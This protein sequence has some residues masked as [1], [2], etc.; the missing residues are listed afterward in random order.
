MTNCN[1]C[2]IQTPNGT[3]TCPACEQKD[4]KQVNPIN[5]NTPRDAELISAEDIAEHKVTACAAYIVFLLVIVAAP[6]SRYVR[7]HVNQG[8]LLV[9]LLGGS[10]VVVCCL[11]LL[12]VPILLLSIISTIFLVFCLLLFI[13]GIIGAVNAFKGK[14]K[15]LPIIGKFRLVKT[16]KP[17][18][19]KFWT[20]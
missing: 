4:N 7:F 18:N 12:S 8:L 16:V 1:N 15:E 17:D 13:L 9:T 11:A 6:S 14:V 3:K 10:S 20:V 5:K 2:G 19:P